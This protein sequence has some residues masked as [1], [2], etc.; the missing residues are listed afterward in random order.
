MSDITI[1]APITLPA[2]VTITA[3]ITIGYQGATGATGATGADGPDTLAEL[4]DV[5]TYDLP[6]ANTPLAEALA[7][8]ADSS[9]LSYV[10]LSGSY[11]DLIDVPSPSP[12]VSEVADLTDA[13]TYEFPTLNTP[14]VNA[15]A[16][17]S[18]TTHNHAGVYDP[19]GS[20]AAAQAAAVQRANH[21][22]SQAISTVT[23]LQTAI[24][25]KSST[26]HT[27]SNAEV[28]TA[29]AASP[30]TSATAMGLGT[31]NTPTFA[32]LNT[33]AGV[34]KFATAPT[35]YI[36]L[37]SYGGSSPS[38]AASYIGFTSSGVR[39]GY[40]S[41]SVHRSESADLSL[42]ANTGKFKL[43]AQSNGNSFTFLEVPLGGNVLE[44]QNATNPQK[45][46]VY[47]TTTG[48][49]YVQLAHDGTNAII[50]TTA[51]EITVTNNLTA[52]GTVTGDS[53][54][55]PLAQNN[56]FYVSGNTTHSGMYNGGG[57]SNLSFKSNGSRILQ[58]INNAGQLRAQLESAGQFGFGSDTTINRLSAGVVGV[59][60]LTASGVIKKGVLTVGTLPGSPTAGMSSYVTD[61]SQTLAAGIGTTLAAGG[62]NFNPVHYNGTNWIIG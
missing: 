44:I 25:G 35:N 31:A 6:T 34:G 24:D 42:W 17:K 27:H 46:R 45:L 22:G 56:G 3:P 62:Q 37:N 52:S 33:T 30:A 57:L 26:S 13:T 28:N 8:K 18:S 14:L 60:N 16:G 20:A 51:G 55:T 58:L 47:G 4:S 23:G 1:S 43:R 5:T 12:G 49:K 32:G 38:P 54:I 40:M 21:T 59:P 2:A 53:Y 50:S 29:I 36:T 11:D 9:S 19:A 10:A 15:L 61:S 7:A 48:S 41:A 39:D